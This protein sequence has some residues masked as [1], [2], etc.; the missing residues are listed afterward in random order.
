MLWQD[1]ERLQM[2]LATG[3]FQQENIALPG[4]FKPPGTLRSSPFG[5]N[6]RPHP[7]PAPATAPT[8]GYGN[9]SQTASQTHNPWPNAHLK[10]TPGFCIRRAI[11]VS[12]NFGNG[13]AG[14]HN[15]SY[16]PL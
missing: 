13:S 7:P 8:Q 11:N 1:F 16:T 4:A 14:H 10:V 6:S 2:E 9:N 5:G 12:S 3:K 15:W